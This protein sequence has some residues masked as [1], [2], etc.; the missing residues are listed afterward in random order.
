MV[1]LVFRKLIVFRN[2]NIACF[3]ISRDFEIAQVGAIT[4]KVLDV[5]LRE[6]EE[7]WRRKTL[8]KFSKVGQFKFLLDFEKL[9]SIIKSFSIKLLFSPSMPNVA[10]L[11]PLRF[12]FWSLKWTM[13]NKGGKNH[14]DCVIKKCECHHYIVLLKWW[15][16]ARLYHLTLKRIEN[17]VLLPICVWQSTFPAILGNMKELSQGLRVILFLR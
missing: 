17:L 9:V 16:E 13:L 6:L 10:S 2:N 11:R 1:S 12:V 4:S 14:V 5:E 7:I 3:D 8:A 15:T